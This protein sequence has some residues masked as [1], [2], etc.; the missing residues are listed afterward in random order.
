MNASIYDVLR[1]RFR[2]TS[3]PIGQ[4][5]PDRQRTLSIIDNL[6]RL[7]NTRRGAL[8]HL[9]DYGLP[10]ISEIYRDVPESIPELQAAIKAAVERYEPRLQHVRVT[11][12]ARDDDAFA[13]TLT[14]LVAGQ[15]A[16]RAPVRFETTFQSEAHVQGARPA[17]VRRA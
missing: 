8:P 6:D 13:M 3:T 1:G 7:F 12:H 11:H 15:L 2:G 4:I 9:P 5:A 17:H 16:G 10:D 14:F